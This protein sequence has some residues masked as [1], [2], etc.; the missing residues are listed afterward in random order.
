MTKNI[1][2]FTAFCTLFF[3]CKES[4]TEHKAT[5]KVKAETP[6]VN[7]VELTPNQIKNAGIVTG[8]P[9]VREIHNSVKVNGV[10]DVPPQ[11]IISVS[12]PLGGYLKSM[13]LLPGMPVRKGSLLGRLEDQQYIQ[14]QQDYLMSKSKLEFLEADYTRQKGL[15]ETQSISN[16][17]LQQVKSDYESQRVLQRALQEKLRLIGINPATLT[18]NNISRHANI[19]SPINGYVNKVNVNIG[20]YVSPTDVLFE[21]VNP[22]NIHLSLTVFEKDVA[23]ISIGQRV[24]CYANN[25]PDKKFIAK[26]E[27]INRNINDDRASEVHCDFE[28]YDKNLLPGMFMNAQIELTNAQATTVPDEAVVRWQNKF[29]V[30]TEE[31]KNKYAMLPIEPG[32]ADNGYTT[33]KTD[34]SGKNIVVKNAYALLMKMK[35]SS[36][37]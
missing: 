37:E 21:L 34:I 33:I 6:A 10:I 4:K 22:A 12:A 36:E 8:T 15:N 5:A 19:Y 14:L 1:I 16:K 29:Y 2:A 28:R 25:N 18:Y 13:N 27:L 7:W 20:K 30:F 26:V 32:I 35:N 9:E 11:N 3:A 24:V 17:V 23:N 31:T